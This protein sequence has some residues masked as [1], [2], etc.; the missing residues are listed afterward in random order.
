MTKL[1][2]IC[3]S[4]REANRKIRG[5]LDG[6]QG[7]LD[8]RSRVLGWLRKV[9]AWIIYGVVR[10]FGGLAFV[11]ALFRDVR[12]TLHFM[13]CEIQDKSPEE[14]HGYVLGRQQEYARRLS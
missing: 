9:A 1:D 2:Y 7:R 13:E 14:V 4:H 10:L 12:Y 5:W 11:D 3:A 6:V 8:D